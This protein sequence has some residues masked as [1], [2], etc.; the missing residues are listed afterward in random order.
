MYISKPSFFVGR[1]VELE[2][3]LH[4]LQSTLLEKRPHFVLIQGDVG[5][6]KTSLLEYF[7]ADQT[8]QNQSLL[9]G[10]G[11]CAMETE[12][13]G[14]IP[15]SELLRMLTEQSI[16]RKLIVDNLVN[17]TKEVAP[18][19]LDIFTA[20]A[21]SAVVKTV[22]ES[23]KWAEHSSYSQEH[24]F[25]Q[26]NNAMNK[27]AKKQPIIAFIDDLQWAD[28]TS[29]GLLFHLARHLESQ[30]VLF[31]CAYRPVEAL[32]TGTNA[33]LFRDIRANLIRYGAKEIV[34]SQGISVMDYVT[35]RYP[36][37]TF[38]A[39]LLT[40]IQTFTDG[41][42]LYVSQ[43]FSMWQE[44]GVISSSLTSDERT[45]WRM[46]QETDELPAVPAISEVLQAR[47]SLLQEELRDILTCASVE[48]EDFTAQVVAKLR[49]ID[50]DKL[51]DLLDTLE[52]HYRLINQ[53][54]EDAE[55][56]ELLI[57]ADFYRFAHRFFRSHIYNRLSGGRRRSLHKQ[58][59]ECLEALYGENIQSIAGQLAIHFREAGEVVKAARYA[60][61]A[62]EFEQ[63]RYG[64]AEGERWLE[65]GLA[66]L[67]KLPPTSEYP[68]LRI[69]FLERSGN[70][71]KAC[72][73][74]ALAGQ[75]Y[76]EAL[77][78]V[79]PTSENA[80]QK[81]SLC[82]ML[83]GIQDELNRLDEMVRFIELGK[84]AL[85]QHPVT[86]TQLRLEIA[87]GFL[88]FRLGHT[89]LAIQL[90][91]QG[92]VISETL[93][94]TSDLAN[95]RMKA[96]NLL[97]IALGNVNQYSDAREAFQKGIELARK[98]NK[99]QWEADCMLNLAFDLV[100]CGKPDE[101]DKLCALA[102]QLAQQIG[103]LDHMAY[104]HAN[105]GLVFL[106]NGKAHDAIAEIGTAIR[107]SEQ[108]NSIWNMPYMCTDMARAYLATG[109]LVEAQKY[110]Q[111]ALSYTQ[112]GEFVYGY[113]LETLARIEAVQH[114]TVEVFLEHFNQAISIYEAAGH[115][116]YA[117]RATRY[118][119]KELVK[120]EQVEKGEQ[121]L[122]NAA[123]ILEE[124]GLNDAMEP[125]VANATN[126]AFRLSESHGCSEQP[127]DHS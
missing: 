78:L 20:G 50:V 107:L 56:K 92:L 106:A 23:K 57:I 100:D 118:L 54:E 90:V 62:M 68:S 12:L 18:A 28:A 36:L 31:L 110:I 126:M 17:F 45:I 117:A 75:R 60:L 8:L 70:G 10:Q 46:M 5:T 82:V 112:K 6:G 125:D 114:E 40:H 81:A 58:V 108:L 9:V 127:L 72:G 105:K 26:F 59:G 34:L 41:H 51:Y 55:H 4:T 96:Y 93:T 113:V 74:Y 47:L 120:A 115:R 83:A 27:L 38:S 44:S 66:L 61:L 73:Q 84:Q 52:N 14:L 109:A 16:Q 116:H 103:D 69:D 22:E 124:L 91:R 15:F 102:K 30:P 43:L 104:A 63:L 1:K 85:L 67:E 64:W 65:F 79:P 19:W 11:R 13:N 99:K 89:T 29:L 101:A 80:S 123:L 122:Q 37:N 76:A 49:H 121:L 95:I 77:S 88:Q 39:D 98:Y 97:G 2:Q 35:R 33:A 87:E 25:V 21:A 71:Y 32:E 48:G 86:E 3:L 94:S 111:R 42:A 24:V 119:G 7:L 53:H